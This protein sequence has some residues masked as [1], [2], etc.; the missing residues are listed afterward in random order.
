MAILAQVSI[1]PLRQTELSS[2]IDSVLEVFEKSKIF[3]KEG[4]MSTLVEGEPDQVFKALKEA[5]EKADEI[6]DFSMVITLSNACP[7]RLPEDK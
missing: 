1:Y 5:F 2:S 6:G 7:F 3:F 4:K